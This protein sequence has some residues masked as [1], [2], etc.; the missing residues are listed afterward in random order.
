MRQDA[1]GIDLED[2]GR[3]TERLRRHGARPKLLYVVPNFQNPTGRLLP[4]DRR[5]ALLAWAAKH[6]CLIVEDDPYGSLYFEGEVAPADVR[7]IKAGD[8]E[9]RVIYLSSFSKTLAPGFRVGWLVAPAALVERFETAKQSG[10]LAS[11]TLDQRIAC[12]A[13]RRGVV[14]RL[15]PRL[16]SGYRARRDTLE[17]SLLT[18]ATELLD[19][20]ITANDQA[21]MWF[22]LVTAD[23]MGW[24]DLAATATTAM[25]N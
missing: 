8:D 18:K 20:A 17:A 12:E 6:D 7:P 16:R 14:D 25:G 4:Q 24:T 11:G 1:G 22:L 23:S 19:A 21:G 9:G 5:R 15:A 3:A 13:L 2:L 10:D